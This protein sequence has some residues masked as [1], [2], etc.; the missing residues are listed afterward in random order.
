MS[1]EHSTCVTARS[2][3]N[4]LPSFYEE[5]NEEYIFDASNSC[6]TG[7]GIGLLASSAIAMSQSMSDI[8]VAGAEAVRIAFRLG[9]LVDEVSQNLEPREEGS[10]PDTWAIVVTGVTEPGVQKEL[11][12]IQSKVVSPPMCHGTVKYSR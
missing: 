3:A 7:V 6:L 10:S 2:D 4:S 11:D 8:P 12:T 5:S 1:G 9:V